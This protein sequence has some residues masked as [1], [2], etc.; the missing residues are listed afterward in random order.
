M[1]EIGFFISRKALGVGKLL[2]A[3]WRSTDK[4]DDIIKLANWTPLSPYIQ[5]F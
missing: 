1:I 4:N 3:L 2:T 5:L